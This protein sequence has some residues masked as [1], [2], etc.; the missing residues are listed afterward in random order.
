MKNS[1]ACC[2][3]ARDN[4]EGYVTAERHIRQ[5]SQTV[6]NPKWHRQIL[7]LVNGL[8]LEECREQYNR[9]IEKRRQTSSP[10]R[11]EEL[12]AIET[13]LAIRIMD[14]ECPPVQY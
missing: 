8:S 9:C 10:Q 12:G 4:R 14:H 2:D 1:T 5:P 13:A 11:L 6:G 7:N 3:F